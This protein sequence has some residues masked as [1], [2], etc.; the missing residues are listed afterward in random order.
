MYNRCKKVI[1][2]YKGNPFTHNGKHYK[3]I[4]G[5]GLLTDKKIKLIHGQYRAAIRN[6]PGDTATMKAVCAM[7]N[8]RS[9]DPAKC[10]DW[11]PA[12]KSGDMEK[13]NKNILPPFFLMKELLAIFEE[14]S[15]DSLL[16]KCKHGGT[17][18]ANEA[19]HHLIWQ[20]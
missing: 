4:G 10:P 14:L 8:H 6:H 1:D 16:E 2:N 17:Q 5:K 9:G 15:I 18:N 3:G 19:F 20:R 13:A 12:T 7:Y 11:C